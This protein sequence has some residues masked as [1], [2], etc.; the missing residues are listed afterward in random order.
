MLTRV[1][2]KAPKPYVNNCMVI[3]TAYTQ[4]LLTD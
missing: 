1:E 4:L 3:A 2:D